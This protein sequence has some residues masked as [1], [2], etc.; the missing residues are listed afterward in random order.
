[1]RSLKTSGRLLN[2]PASPIRKLAPFANIAKKKGVKVYHLNIGDPDIETPRV[3]LNVLNNWDKPTI[4]YSQSQGEP[5]FLESLKFYYQHLGFTFIKTKHLQV[6]TGGSEAISMALFATTEVGNEVISFEPLYTNYNSYAAVNDI[7]IVSVQTEAKHGFHLP[8]EKEIEKKITEKT[9]AILF[10]NP[11]NPTGTVYTKKEVELLVRL[12]KK[13]NLFLIADEVYREFVYD[14]RQHVSILSYFEQIPGQAI[15]I[16][17]LS[18]RYSLC[19]ARLGILASL[20]KDIIAGVLR[21]AQG[22]LSAGLID[23]IMAAEL[24]GVPNSYFSQVHKEY[25]AR[26]DILYA[27]LK[28]IPGVTVP[29]PEG[30]FYCIVKLPVKDSENFCKF[31]LTDF[32]LRGETVMLAPGS[33]FYSTPGLGKNEV[34]IAYVLNIVDLKK[35]LEILKLALPAYNNLSR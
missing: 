30:A 32:N 15:L 7:K 27:G 21:I 29:K 6:T 17:S 12:A 24:T 3:M 13:Y 28:S 35:S 33:G 19:G 11:N 22:R 34:R 8:A 16:D 23:Q 25:Q 10:C 9:K 2:I 1:M 5:V 26:R 14:N 20:N 4:S 18:K 31:L